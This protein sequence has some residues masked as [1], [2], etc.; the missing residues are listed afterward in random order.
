MA[1]VTK[2]C[3]CKRYAFP[4]RY[5]WQ[6]D[7]FIEQEEEPQRSEADRLYWQDYHDRVRDLRSELR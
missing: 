1:R 7:D 4:H 2:T 5:Q 6:C 3:R